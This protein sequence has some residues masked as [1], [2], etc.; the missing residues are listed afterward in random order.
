MAGEL[1]RQTWA[2]GL[3]S[4]AGTPVAAT[5]ALF[6]E[7]ESRLSRERE[8]RAHRFATGTR[9]NVRAHT[10]GPQIAGGTVSMP[11]SASEII[12]LLLIGL[13]GGVTPTT[14]AAGV[15]LW[16][17]VPGSTALD[18]ATLEWYDGARG[19]QLAGTYAN[20]L[21]FAGNVR[22]RHIVTAE[23]FGHDLSI[24][25]V[26][27][28]DRSRVPDIIEGWESKCYID[29]HEGTP[30]STVKANLLINWDVLIDNQLGRKYWAN[31]TNAMGAV[32][33][34]EIAV[35][36]T[37]LIEAANA[38]AATEFA[39]WDADTLRLVRLEFG[40]ND[41]ISGE[42]KKFIT[43]DLPGAWSAFDLGQ[44]DEQTRAYELRL[45]GVYDPTNQYA[46]QIRC[47][48]AR[49][50]AFDNGS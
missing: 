29:S 43:I 15:Y 28:V 34:G 24:E 12:E 1:W 35:E 20:S 10:L 11:L 27:N 4:A 22:E 21:R 32:V 33:T 42:Y 26:T 16:T 13:K 19:L 46:V 47:Q 23:L 5:R 50:A 9:D 48:N 7:P 3:E 49:S 6:L 36:A 2:I 45:T 39:N 14:P 41:V 44:T 30:G 8:S 40:N 38:Q 18:P 25:A 17:F 31:N 37:L